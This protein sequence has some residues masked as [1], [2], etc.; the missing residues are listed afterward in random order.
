MRHIPMLF[1]PAMIDA[2]SEGRKTETRRALKPQPLGEPWFWPGDEVDPEPC[3]FDGYT[4]GVEPCG[5]SSR[6]IN[7]PIRAALEADDLIWVKEAH[8]AYGYWKTTDELTASG[9]PKRSFVRYPDVPVSFDKN[10]LLSQS[11]E[12]KPGWYKRSSLFMPK[13]DSRL[14]LRVKSY[15]I[16]RLQAIDEAGAESEGCFGDDEIVDVIGTPHGPSEITDFRYRVHGVHDDELSFECPVECYADLWD[17]INGAG[18]WDA[19]P[20]VS[21]IKFEVLKRNIQE[22]AA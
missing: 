5:A 14:T 7:E 16:E 1:S 11:L 12:K 2:I 15:G 4:S 18:A 21:V 22:V 3:W 8:Y 17:Q 6:E 9:K 10:H 19:D 20:W 13:A